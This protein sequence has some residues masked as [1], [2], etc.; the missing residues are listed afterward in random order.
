MGKNITE[1]VIAGKIISVAGEEDAAYM[2]EVAAFINEKIS[3]LQKTA[4]YGRMSAEMKTIL[5]GMNL[6]DEYFRERKKNRILETELDL[7]NQELYSLRHE[8]I[9]AKLDLEKL[10]KQTLKEES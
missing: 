6:T 2:T 7:K 4:N 3:E 5:L 8:L 1:V 9:N 10:Q